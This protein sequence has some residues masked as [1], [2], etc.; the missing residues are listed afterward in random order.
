MSD[1]PERWVND[2]LMTVNPRAVPPASKTI[3]VTGVAR[4]GTS[5]VAHAL[6]LGGV[7]M[8]RGLDGVVFED[9][10]IADALI[11]GDAE[12]LARLAAAR[13]EQHQVWGFKRP[14]LFNNAG[15]ELEHAFRNPHFI[16]TYR[17][18]VAIA[19]RNRIS[20]YFEEK[21]ALRAAASDLQRCVEFA[22][23]L[24]CPALLVSYEKALQQPAALADSLAAFCGL[25]LDEG[26]R[27]RM[28]ASIEANPAAYVEGSRRLFEGYVDCIRDGVVGGWCRQ[29][30]EN[31]PVLLEIS[32]G[33][34]ASVAVLANG[35]RGDL[36][37]AGLGSGHHGFNLDISAHVPFG[38]EIVAV[39]VHDRVFELNG[40]GRTVAQLSR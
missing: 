12:A 2:G 25:A 37:E 39:R 8:G 36:A 34:A 13:N 14:H 35:F 29:I 10:E 22:L 1:A 28:A 32:V 30:G 26:V 4:S 6:A 27:E 31:A 9:T 40:S 11:G 18:P 7:F 17:D 33:G 24:T 23:L 19:K 20:E 15:P 38:N 21:A 3:I 16:V 5:M